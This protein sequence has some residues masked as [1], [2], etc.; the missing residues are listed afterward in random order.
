VRSD[1]SNEAKN[2]RTSQCTNT[3]QRRTPQEAAASDH[4]AAHEITVLSDQHSVGLAFSAACPDHARSPNLRLA[5]P[6]MII[7]ALLGPLARR[8]GI[9][10]AR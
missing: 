6:S 3:T 7:R 8:E 9:G 10:A 2:V 4:I 1:A 5:G